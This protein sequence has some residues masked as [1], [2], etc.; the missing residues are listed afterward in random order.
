[1]QYILFFVMC[2]L[3]KDIHFLIFFG[4]YLLSDVGLYISFTRIL[5]FLRQYCLNVKCFVWFIVSKHVLLGR[6]LNG[7]FLVDFLV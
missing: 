5:D 4:S 7:D 2:H 1:M 3:E 6:Y